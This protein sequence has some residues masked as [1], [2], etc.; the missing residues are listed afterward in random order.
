[1][2]ELIE[3]YDSYIKLLN[4]ELRELASMAYNHGWRSSRYDCG[5]KLREKILKLEEKLS[6]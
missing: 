3:V 6:A 1:M 4:D 5:K 2:K